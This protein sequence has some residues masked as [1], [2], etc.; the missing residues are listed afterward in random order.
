MAAGAGSGAGCS[1]GSACTPTQRLQLALGLRALRLELHD[2]L[3]RRGRVGVQRR[4]VGARREAGA[5]AARLRVRRAPGAAPRPSARCAGAGRRPAT[6]SR[7]WRCRRP[8]SRRRP[9]RRRARRRRWPSAASSALRLRPQKSKSYE[10]SSAD[11]A[12]GA[13]RAGDRRR[14]EAVLADSARAW[15]G[16]R[17][18]ASRRRRPS[19]RRRPCRPG[20]RAPGR[21]PSS[22]S[23]AARGRSR[24]VELRDR[25]SRPA[26]ARRRRPARRPPHRAPGRPRARRRTWAARP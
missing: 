4:E 17:A 6:G 25:R 16:R 23:P 11:V 1:A 19:S 5:H 22:A 14:I 24:W 12:A 7:S 18:R 26:P 21:R 9:A 3:A 8:A 13:R 10:K 15:P 2:A 20:A